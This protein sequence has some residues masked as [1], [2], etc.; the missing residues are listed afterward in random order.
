MTS[1]IEESADGVKMP[2]PSIGVALG[3]L[4]AGKVRQCWRFALAL[5]ALGLVLGNSGMVRAIVG[6]ATIPAPQ[7]APGGTFEWL[8][9]LEGPGGR[10][11]GSLIAADWVLTAAHCGNPTVAFIGNDTVGVA[12]VEVVLH[13]S[14]TSG[15]PQFDA[16]L[17]RIATPS[18]IRPVNR[19][20]A[21]LTITA[22]QTPI[23]LAGWGV[24]NSGGAPV[25]EPRAG[26]TT[27]TSVNTQV[28]TTG[29][30]TIGCD[31]DSGGPM[32]YRGTLVG[33]MSSTDAT[34]STFTAGAR[35]RSIADWVTS[36]AGPSSPIA[37]CRAQWRTNRGFGQQLRNTVRVL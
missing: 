1:A 35:F 20:V 29:A 27:V 31:G 33:V 7:V 4:L 16:S 22:G 25:A 19:S 36:I 12:I 6:G 8:V 11:T 32:L 3:A 21:S 13:P 18:A 24:A 34:C 10:C 23:T 17:L 2:N 37:P 26:D 28:L 5:I 9:R 30:P 15:Q 14:F